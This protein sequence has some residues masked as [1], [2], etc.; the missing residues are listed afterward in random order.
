[1]STPYVSGLAALVWTLCPQLTNAQ[2]RSVISSTAKD[3]GVTGWDP[4]FG[5]GR[6]RAE[7][8]VQAA[9]PPPILAV[10][11]D[12][13]L[14]LADA[15]LGPWPQTL[16]VSNGAPCASL[17]WTGAEG[18]GWLDADPDSGQASS[19][20]PSEVAVS[21]D[22]SGLSAGTTYNA[23][24]TVDSSTLGVQEAPQLVD[25]KFIYSDTPLAVRFFPLGL[26]D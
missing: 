24:L 18:E 3:L 22:K 17:D 8:A 16:L 19:S 11:Q 25:V 21:V 9:N 10:N 5:Y 1:M 2:L 20:Q 12:E 26:A 15:S 6:I 13:M 14:F 7:K 4:Y 23:T